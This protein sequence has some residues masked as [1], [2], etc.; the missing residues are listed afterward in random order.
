MSTAHLPMS[1]AH[2]QCELHARQHKLHT[3]NL[4]CTVHSVSCPLAN[5]RCTLDNVN[6]TLTTSTAHLP[7]SAARSHQK[8]H[9]FRP[10]IIITTTEPTLKQLKA[11]VHNVRPTGHNPAPTSRRVG[12]ARFQN[13]KLFSC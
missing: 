9:Y 4:N 7:M 8:T 13:K 6:C 1:T 10:C 2:E 3:D 5:V 11:V 12:R